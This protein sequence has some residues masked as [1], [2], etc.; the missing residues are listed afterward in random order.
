[1]KFI[2]FLNT[3]ELW[4]LEPSVQ[5]FINWLTTC[6]GPIRQQVFVQALYCKSSTFFFYIANK[7]GYL[8]L[9]VLQGQ[10]TV[11]PTFT[12]I[13]VIA[14][15]LCLSPSVVQRLCPGQTGHT[16]VY[17]QLIHDLK[18]L[19]SVSQNFR[20]FSQDCGQVSWLVS[21]LKNEYSFL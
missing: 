7:Y 15:P 17:V 12:D 16:F 14:S 10:S 1:M 3:T 6:F 9:R 13:S 21:H 8:E 4:Y 5:D 18:L 11:P 2:I 19:T 20:I